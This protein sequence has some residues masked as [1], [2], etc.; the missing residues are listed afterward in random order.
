M[1]SDFNTFGF[2]KMNKLFLKLLSVF[3]LICLLLS[4]SNCRE[5]PDCIHFPPTNAKYV[6][7]IFVDSATNEI[8]VQDQFF[9]DNPK[10]IDPD[11]L[12]LLNSSLDTLPKNQW[13]VERHGYGYIIFIYVFDQSKL[14]N[15]DTT[16]RD[17]VTYYIYSGNSDLDTILFNYHFQRKERCYSITNDTLNCFVNG[18]PAEFSTKGLINDVFVIKK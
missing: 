13:I 3:L 18:K 11:S 5:E 12:R 14:P 7:F 17:S 8:L 10:R 2:S 4:A 1:F 9:L 6:A 15:V 16:T